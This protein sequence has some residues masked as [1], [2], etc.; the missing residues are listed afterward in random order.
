MDADW[1]ILDAVLFSVD[2]TIFVC[3]TNLF[4]GLEPR[5]TNATESTAHHIPSELFKTLDAYQHLTEL[6]QAGCRGCQ[7]C[8]QPLTGSL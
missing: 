1:Y 3:P 8:L 2:E 6:Q 4:P 7:G 5:P